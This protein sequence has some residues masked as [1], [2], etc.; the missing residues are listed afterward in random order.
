[1]SKAIF[2][3]QTPGPDVVQKLH[4]DTFPKRCRHFAGV[5][6]TDPQ[7]RC[8]AGVLMSDVTVDES[9]R[10]QYEGRGP[11]YTASHSLPCFR[12]DDPHGV[13]HCEH[14]SFPT[15][16]EIAAEDAEVEQM[17]ARFVGARSAI[18]AHSKGKRGVSGRID[19]PACKA[20]GALAY[21]VSGYNG[22]VHAKCDTDDCVN[23][24][25]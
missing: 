2:T 16:E 14:Q 7:K 13:C 3:D 25:E 1:M 19:C 22:H 4:E 6:F 20:K 23:F 11:I 15:P 21:S 10:Y 17:V 18:L 8:K 24:M 9:Y 12:D 5:N